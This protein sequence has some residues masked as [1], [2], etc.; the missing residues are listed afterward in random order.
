MDKLLIHYHLLNIQLSTILTLSF[1]PNETKN[2]SYFLSY[3]L[4]LSVNKTFDYLLFDFVNV[5]LFFYGS[6]W[7]VTYVPTSLKLKEFVTIYELSS[8]FSLPP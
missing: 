2:C 1:S 5:M 7:I 4:K 3:S 6:K 8:S